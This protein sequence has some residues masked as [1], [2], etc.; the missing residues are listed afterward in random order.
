MIQGKKTRSIPLSINIRKVDEETLK[1]T[2]SVNT[3]TLDRYGTV[4][5]PKGANVEK[6]MLNPVVLWLHNSDMALPGIPIARCAELDIREE[7]I[8][9]TTEFNK[10]DPLALRI[11]QAYKDNFLHAWSIGF[12]PKCFEEITPVNFEEIKKKY[13][14]QNLIIS[15]EEFEANQAWGLWVIYEWELLEYSAVPVPGNPDALTKDAS[16]EIFTRELVTRGLVD[17][18]DVGKINFRELLARQEKAKADVPVTEK[19]P[20]EAAPVE[21]TEEAKKIP[22]EAAKEIVPVAESVKTSEE[23][24]TLPVENTEKVEE[25]KEDKTPIKPTEEVPAAPV[26]PVAETIAPKAED[27]PSVEVLELKQK[28]QELSDRVIKLELSLSELKKT[29]DV[30]NIDRVR[31]ISQKNLGKNPDKFFSNFLKQK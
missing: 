20:A 6:F 17:E 26:V 14:L 31:A 11:F 24:K 7:E 21:K 10:N 23:S 19:Q 8:V 18:K 4:V 12:I 2:H 16:E 15:Q 5:L 25:A 28:N 9:V 13:N 22:E 1:I 29:L 30:D 3:K 27:K